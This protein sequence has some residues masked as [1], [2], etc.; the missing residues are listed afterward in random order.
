LRFSRLEFLVEA[1]LG[2]AT[3]PNPQIMLRQSSDFG[4]TFNNE[5]QTGLG[6]VGEFSQRVMFWRLGSARGKVFEVTT[7]ARTPVRITDAY[8]VIQPSTERG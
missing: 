2:D 7:T 1:G 6:G 3:D 5:L 8:L 4:K